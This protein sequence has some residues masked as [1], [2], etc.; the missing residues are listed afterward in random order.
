MSDWLPSL[1]T[2]AIASLVGRISLAEALRSYHG[3]VPFRPAEP[4]RRACP[5]V[6]VNAGS[7]AEEW[8]HNH[9]R[10]QEV[11]ALGAYFLRDVVVSGHCYCFH[12]GSYLHDGSEPARIGRRFA[13]A[14]QLVPR[15]LIHRRRTIPIHRPVLVVAGPG[16]PIWGHWLLDFL[17]RLA[18][19]KQML[20]PEFDRFLLPIPSDTPDWVPHMM[21]FFCGVGADR[22]VKYDRESE[23]VSCSRVCMPT[24][25]HTDYFLH[26]YMHEFYGSFITPDDDATPE[27]FC[28]SRR[29]FVDGTRS[30]ARVFR[31]QEAFEAAASRHG[32]TVLQPERL[33]FR[34]QISL[35]AK[36]RVIVGEY[37]SGLH[38][39]LFSPPGTIVGQVCMP[40]AIQS[41]I[42]G[43]CGQRLAYLFPDTQ[44]RDAEGVEQISVAETLIEDFLAAISSMKRDS[45]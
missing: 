13:A 16:Y 31:Q 26:S 41:R 18:I 15:V 19:A 32:F 43:L 8:G 24:Y 34:A 36:A 28:V 42:A 11:G 12:D 9:E 20:G 38:S 4:S 7:Q 29:D 39:A 45:V 44:E 30:V 5:A 37:G 10:G 6:L 3:F 2:T 25:A 35:F 22:L 1:R 27:R 23:S 40:N 14:E 21:E 17:P 33:S